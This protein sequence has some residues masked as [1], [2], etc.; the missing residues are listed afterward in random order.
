MSL[1]TSNSG[2]KPWNFGMALPRGG[3]PK[4]RMKEEDLRECP[5]DGQGTLD[6]PLVIWAARLTDTQ[7]RELA[8][9]EFDYEEDLYRAI[10]ANADMAKTAAIRA[11]CTVAWIICPVHSSKYVYDR[12]GNKIPTKWD[13]NGNPVEYLVTDADPHLTVR[14]GTRED[15]VHV[16]GHINVVVDKRGFPTDFMKS[17]QRRQNGHLT[18]GD[19]RTMELFEWGNRGNLNEERARQEAADYELF[20][21]STVSREIGWEIEDD[22]DDD[23]YVEKICNFDI[24]EYDPMDYEGEYNDESTG[25]NPEFEEYLVHLGTTI[26][27]PHIIDALHTPHLIGMKSKG[28]G[29]IC[30]DITTS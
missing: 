8:V 15:L 1:K 16:H 14:L 12:D 17:Y 10:D 7:R 22:K 24:P 26:N 18:N 28:Q 2:S 9:P 19:D 21:T 27:P 6:N 11:Q 5:R 30:L 4:I 23:D 25:L 29:H 3:P 20:K 13:R